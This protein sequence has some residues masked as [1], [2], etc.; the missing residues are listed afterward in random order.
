[1]P[2]EVS[3]SRQYRLL[4]VLLHEEHSPE[5]HHREDQEEKHW[6]G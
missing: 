1:V 5:I 4:N 2:V 3:R 6:Q